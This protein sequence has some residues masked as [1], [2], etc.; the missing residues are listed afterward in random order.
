M[1]GSITTIRIIQ[2]YQSVDFPCRLWKQLTYIN[3]VARE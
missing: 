3:S 2:G 1:E